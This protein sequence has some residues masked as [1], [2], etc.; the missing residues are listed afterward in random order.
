MDRLE[1][2]EGKDKKSKNLT[3]TLNCIE[4]QTR[5]RRDY[6]DKK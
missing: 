6:E 3:I 5:K 2:R 4:Y 1:N